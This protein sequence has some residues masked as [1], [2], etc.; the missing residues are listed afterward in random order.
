MHREKKGR[1]RSLMMLVL[2]LAAV[3]LFGIL[4]QQALALP[5]FTTAEKGIGPCQKCHTMATVHAGATHSTT[6]CATCHTTNTATAPL[7]SACASCH[8]EATIMANTAHTV[9]GCGTTDGCHGY[10]APVTATIAIDTVKPSK[11]VKAKTKMTLSGGVTPVDTAA[12]NVAWAVQFKKG[13]K[14]IQS[15]AGTATLGFLGGAM[16]FSFAY[17]P[18][19][20]GSYRAQASFFNLLGGSKTTSK[21]VAFK[22]K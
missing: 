7:P 22:A 12:K 16:R 10:V 1:G 18:K 17:Q 6:P 4:A 8:T 14:W 21:W 11:A 3:A 20:K 13:S 9:Q 15:K 2:V 5:T 19:L